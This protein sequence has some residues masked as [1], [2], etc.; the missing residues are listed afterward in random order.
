MT[1]DPAVGLLYW[2][3]HEHNIPPGQF[4]RMPEGEKVILRAFYAHE[5]ERRRAW[6][7]DR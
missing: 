4:W 5:M 6:P 3:F 7:S 2:L 1:S